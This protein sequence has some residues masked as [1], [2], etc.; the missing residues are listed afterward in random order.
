MQTLTAGTPVLKVKIYDFDGLTVYSSDAGQIGDDASENRG[1]VEAVREGTPAS[2][3]SNRDTFRAISGVVEDRDLVEIYI[4]IRSAEGEIEGVFELYTDVTP[5]IGRVGG[6]TARFVAGILL[7]FGLLYG[8]LFL[9]VRRADRIIKTQYRDLQDNEE[10]IKSHNA[11][12]V[13][14]HDKLE[15]RVDERT[16][17]LGQANE[18]LKVEIGERR[19]AETG[20]RESEAR[21]RDL[22][23]L[24]P[25]AIFVHAEGEFL[26]V[27]SAAVKLFG[28][29][30]PGDLIGTNVYDMIHPQ[31]RALAED[32]T[33]LMAAG[34][35][36]P[37]T[38]LK[39]RRRDGSSVIVEV[40]AKSIDYQGR[41]AIQSIH[42]DI[43]ERKAIEN[44]RRETQFLL[45]VMTE[46]ATDGIFIKD[47]DGRYRM[48]NTTGAVLLGMNADH[49]LG[50][51]D[52]AIFPAERARA[53]M[54]ED[55][56]IMDSGEV[57]VVE[58]VVVE[59]GVERVLLTTKGPC[60]DADGALMGLIGVVRDVTEERRTAAALREAHDELESR[61]RER[62]ADLAAANASL[63]AAKEEA[64]HASRAKSEFLAN[65]SHELRTPAQR[66]HRLRR[67][68][69]GRLHGRAEREAGGVRR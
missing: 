32:R 41:P 29:T 34:G 54:A 12:L 64:E 36:L 57:R 11:A 53:I 18:A 42:R 14:A 60:R 5:L 25:D 47:V 2:K 40:I 67:H 51:D 52:S 21:Y 20:L 63:I 48:L 58:E 27:N 65:T 8:V 33:R 61:V 16:A 17:E 37:F 38:E 4:P 59:D 39:V 6:S 50:K 1:F 30:A 19:Q 31:D 3:L 22:V 44:E 56:A 66:G 35:E 15:A 45:R 7:A 26:F 9:I 68:A 28:V 49:V 43:T 13:E 23:E 24:S 55:R 46:G 62:T 10:R 69:R